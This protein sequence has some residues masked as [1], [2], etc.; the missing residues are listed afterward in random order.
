MVMQSPGLEFQHFDNRTLQYF[1]DASFDQHDR[2]YLVKMSME[3]PPNATWVGPISIRLVLSTLHLSLC[4]YL[5][6]AAL[7]VPRSIKQT[8]QKTGLEREGV[9]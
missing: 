6:N 9:K 2:I 4:L 3:M 7:L 5:R 8:D 1:C